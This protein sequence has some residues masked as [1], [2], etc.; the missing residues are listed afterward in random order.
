M[1]VNFS[2]NA[3]YKKIDVIAKTIYEHSNQVFEDKKMNR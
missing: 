2:E 3:P 1:I